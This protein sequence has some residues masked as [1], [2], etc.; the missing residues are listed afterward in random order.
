VWITS[1]NEPATRLYRR[2]RFQFTGT[3]KPNA[4]TPNLIELE[5]ARTLDPLL[6]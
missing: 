3:T 5:M 2:C 4:H 6:G 1:G